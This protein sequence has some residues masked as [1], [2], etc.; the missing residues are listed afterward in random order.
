MRQ[1]IDSLVKTLEGRVLFVFCFQ[2]N[3]KLPCKNRFF[4]A[5]IETQLACMS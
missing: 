2:F 5:T 1:E 4:K 3:E